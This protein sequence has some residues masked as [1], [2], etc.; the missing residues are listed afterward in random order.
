MSQ[1]KR[2][3][4]KWSADVTAHSDALDLEPHVFS[5]DDSAE[6]AGRSPQGPPREKRQ[7]YATEHEDYTDGVA[8]PPDEQGRSPAQQEKR[9]P[10]GDDGGSD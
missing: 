7:P 10:K 9:A 6:I 4:K 3:K 5:K 2:T 8:R 1:A